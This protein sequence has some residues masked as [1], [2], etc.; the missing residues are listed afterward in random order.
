MVK[1]VIKKTAAKKTPVK[2]TAA[3]KTPVKKNNSSRKSTNAGTLSGKI[4][5]NKYKVRIL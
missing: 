4:A 2:K 5:R 3:K 1:K